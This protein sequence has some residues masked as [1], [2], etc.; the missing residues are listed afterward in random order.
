MRQKAVVL[1]IAIAITAIYI[2]AFT[3]E[4]SH[5][6][7]STMYSIYQHW[8][9]NSGMYNDSPASLD[10]ESIKMTYYTKDGRPVRVGFLIER[11]LLV[12]CTEIWTEYAEDHPNDPVLRTLG[13]FLFQLNAEEDALS[14]YDRDNRLRIMQHGREIVASD[15][16]AQLAGERFF[17]EAIT[18]AHE[19]KETVVALDGAVSFQ[20]VIPGKAKWQHEEATIASLPGREPAPEPR[21]KTVVIKPQRVIEPEEFEQVQQ[22][23]VQEP[24]PVTPEPE[25]PEPQRRPKPSKDIASMVP[26][27]ELPDIRST[28]L[29]D[30]LQ[31]YSGRVLTR[32]VLQNQVEDP[33]AFIQQGFPDYQVEI[34]GNRY[35]IRRDSYEEQLG[36]EIDVYSTRL[37]D[38]LQI[39]STSDYRIEDGWI[40][41]PSGERVSTGNL[42]EEEIA[43]VAPS[44][45]AL[46][47]QHRSLGKPLIHFL[48]TPDAASTTLVLKGEERELYEMHSYLQL[49]LLLNHWWQGRTV[50]F[51]ITE[52]KKVNDYIEFSGNLVARKNGGNS[53]FDFAEVRFHLN[54][55]YRIDLAMMFLTPASSMNR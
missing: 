22:E 8:L 15:L 2:G 1:T 43:E 30:L 9:A 18:F 10:A 14:H 23:P 50:Y 11:G 40:V 35:R 47:N 53:E 6:K 7:S 16:Y 52:L 28:T 41:L 39:S 29:R 44:L 26:A 49:L 24:E 25:A 46:C 21:Q 36:S 12:E 5:F 51:G 3:P 32:K 42:T 48:L 33:V 27:S 19:G 4:R 45:V 20:L 55:Y 34:V 54:K 38:G 31:A 37:S 17:P 13:A